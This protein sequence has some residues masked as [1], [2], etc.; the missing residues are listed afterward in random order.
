MPGQHSRQDF[1]R[2]QQQAIATA[3]EMQRRATLPPPM[4]QQQA[5]GRQ[6]YFS[7]PKPS[8][9]PQGMHHQVPSQQ[10]RQRACYGRT[11]SG[12]SGSRQ[13]P[14][15]RPQPGWENRRQCNSGQPGGQNRQQKREAPPSMPSMPQLFELFGKLGGGAAQ[16]KSDPIRD[17]FSHMGSGSAPT[18]ESMDSMLIMMLLLMLRQ[19]NADQGLLLALMYIMM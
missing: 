16:E 1:L 2:M 18:E 17:A 7:Q 5:A 15:Q 8:G 12:G 13:D 11:Q 14:W 19:E 10:A 4:P 9:K 3:R 6:P